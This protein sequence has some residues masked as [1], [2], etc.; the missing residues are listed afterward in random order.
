[1][2]TEKGTDCWWRLSA[3]ELIG[4]DIMNRLNLAPGQIQKGTV[5][6]NLQNIVLSA[7]LVLTIVE[8]AFLAGYYGYLAR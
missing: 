5:L 6:E 1:M 8:I 2:I 3:E 4:N 7:S